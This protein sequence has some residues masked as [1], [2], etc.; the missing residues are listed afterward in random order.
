VGY[1]P[2]GCKE[3]DTIELLSTHTHDHIDMYAI[4]VCMLNHFSC[5]GL[6]ATAWNTVA[7][8]AHL[9]KGFSRHEYWCGL[10]FPSPGD[11]PNL[12]IE[13]ETLIPPTLAVWFFNTSATWEVSLLVPSKYLLNKLLQ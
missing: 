6:F 13:P 10:A 12:G 9:S 4:S 2:G 3:S 1:N 11:L 8:Q 5:V 7:H